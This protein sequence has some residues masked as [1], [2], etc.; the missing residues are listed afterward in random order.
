MLPVSVSAECTAHPNI[1]IILCY[2]KSYDFF[3]VPCSLQLG[4][5]SLPQISQPLS[6]TRVCPPFG[7][8]GRGSQFGRLKKRPSTLSTLWP[9]LSREVLVY[10]SLCCAWMCLSIYTARACASHLRALLC[11][12]CRCLST[13]SV[14]HL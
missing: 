14:L 8:G 12:P 1:C 10:S 7:T 3:I 5:L 6:S 4:C 13:E 2:V 9:L 11:W